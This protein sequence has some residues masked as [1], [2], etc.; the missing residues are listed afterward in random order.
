MASQSDKD[1][2]K[3]QARVQ[4]DTAKAKAAQAKAG[5]QGKK[6]A[7]RADAR[8]QA[9]TASAKSKQNGGD[10]GTSA[11]MDQREAAAGLNLAGNDPMSGRRGGIEMPTM[12]EREAAS[13]LN[14]AGNDTMSGRRMPDSQFYNFVHQAPHPFEILDLGLYD[15]PSPVF[16]DNIVEDELAVA[17]DPH[18]FQIVKVPGED[19]KVRVVIGTVSSVIPAE[20][21]HNITNATQFS[22][23]DGDSL[24]L[25]VDLDEDDQS[26]TKVTV[27]KSAPTEDNTTA[28]VRL[29]IVAVDNNKITSITNFVKGSMDISSCGDNHFFTSL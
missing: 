4:A 7:A 16:F 23:S 27:T 3:A 5:A 21:N 1:H 8:T 13:G 12:D 11:R 17:P 25:K 9:D 15:I 22:M 29:G 26:V 19:R 28:E 6:D 14:L 20:T 24:Y 2:A 10:G 18:S